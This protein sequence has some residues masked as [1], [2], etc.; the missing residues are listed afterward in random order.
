MPKINLRDLYPDFYK[1]DCII[2][3]PEEVLS[4][5]V[6]HERREAAY[7][8]KMYRYKAQYSLDR[9]DGIENAI[10]FVS[11]SPDE[12]YERKLTTQQLHA[13]IAAL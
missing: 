7:A 12:I 13:A 11:Y 8:R 3:I 5:F 1:A 9:A 2:D 4:V 6:E 10:Q